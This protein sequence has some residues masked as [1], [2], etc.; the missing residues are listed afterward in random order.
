MKKFASLV[1]YIGLFALTMFS[2]RA[3]NYNQNI[4]AIF[5]SG[6]P[7]TGWTTDTQAGVTVALRAKNRE[8][9]NTL[10]VNGVYNEPVGLQAPNNNRA[11][12]NW[13]FSISTTSGVLADYDW[14]VGVDSDETGCSVYSIL[15]VLTTWNDNSYGDASTLNGQG[16]EGLASAFPNSTV[17]QQSQNLVFAGGNPLLDATYS[18]TLY[19]VMKNAGSDGVKIA[20]TTITVV[21][22][23]GGTPCPDDDGDGVPND[24]DQC[25]CSG[26]GT[27]VDVN[28]SQPGTTTIVNTLDSATGCTLQDQVNKIIAQVKAGQDN[29]GEYQKLIVA[30]AK[31]LYDRDLITRKQYQELVVGAAK[32]KWPVSGGGCGGGGPGPV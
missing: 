20:S 31:D 15:P 7:D 25:P 32:A 4:T 3:L 9:G 23:A 6:N 13:E 5:G 17:A 24:I 11:R 19:A 18:Y 29:N 28:G 8:D 21:V 16:Q 12:W 27:L 30:W 10:N 26:L 2:A 14:Y 22:G 1:Y